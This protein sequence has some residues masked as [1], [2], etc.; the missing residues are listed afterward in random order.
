MAK[1]DEGVKGGHPDADHCWRGGKG[2]VYEPPILADVI[3][4]MMIV[5]LLINLADIQ[6]QNIE[7]FAT[8]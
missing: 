2:G 5:E 1:A 6:D 7:N 4:I 8:L 3:R